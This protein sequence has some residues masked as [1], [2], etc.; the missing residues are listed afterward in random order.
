MSQ[1]VSTNQSEYTNKYIA[2]LLHPFWDS[3]CRVWFSKTSWA[4]FV[5]SRPAPLTNLISNWSQLSEMYCGMSFSTSPFILSILNSIDLWQ[6]FGWIPHAGLLACLLLYIDLYR[7]LGE[8]CGDLK[9]GET[10]F[11][12]GKLSATKWWVQQKRSFSLGS[13][14]VYLAELSWTSTSDNETTWPEVSSG[15]LSHVVRC[16]TIS[17]SDG[18]DL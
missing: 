16:L 14:L 11:E 15:I 2:S 13:M 6:F 17:N 4:C 18:Q 1:H 5:Y 12:L 8:S 10:Y 7:F 9:S 3:I